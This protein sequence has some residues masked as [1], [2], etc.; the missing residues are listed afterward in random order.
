MESVLKNACTIKIEKFEG[1]FDLLFY[2]IE[3]NEIDIYDI[4]ISQ[5]TDQYIDYLHAM[6][7]LDLEIASEFLIMAATLLH[8]KSKM[9][10]P[11]RKETE[12]EPE[13]PREELI[14]RL[15][16]YKKYKHISTELKEREKEFKKIFYKQSETY[17]FEYRP[18]LLNISA[19]ELKNVFQNILRKNK[20]KVNNTNEGNIRQI[21]KAE[22]V[23]LKSKIREVLK[24]LKSKPFFKF[25]DEY[26]LKKKSKTEVVTGFL[27]ILE[28]SKLKRADIRQ[29]KIF[30]DITV[31]RKK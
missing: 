2:L 25:S 22:K 28:L 20:E 13:D 29:K 7:Q 10:L 16:E 30:S 11:S 23:T 31:H 1:P 9:L 14:T 19:D 27:A 21:L 5:I 6:H 4:P 18:K 17:D 3:K 15:I 12:N 24:I 26:S 8:I